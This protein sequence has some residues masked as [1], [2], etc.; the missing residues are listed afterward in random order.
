MV[1]KMIGETNKNICKG[2]VEKCLIL[3]IFKT[4]M[5]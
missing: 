4:L 1:E 5:I 2:K 3:K